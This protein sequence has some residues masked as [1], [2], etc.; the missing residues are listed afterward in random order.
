MPPSVF[1]ELYVASNDYLS[2]LTQSS[3]HQGLF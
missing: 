1:A 3:L 2:Q